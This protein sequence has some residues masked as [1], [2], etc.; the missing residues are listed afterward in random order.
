MNQAFFFKLYLLNAS[1]QT[2]YAKIGTT[3]TYDGWVVGFTPSLVAG[4]W[5]K[6][7]MH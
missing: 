2:C 7:M 1:W 3:Q 4:V 5:T 6:T